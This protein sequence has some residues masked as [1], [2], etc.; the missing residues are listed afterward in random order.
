M[1]FIDWL[2]HAIPLFADANILLLTFLHYEHLSNLM[3]YVKNPNAP[4]NILNL[5]DLFDL[6]AFIY[7][8]H[9]H[10]PPKLLC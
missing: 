2:N 4:L 3:Y 9:G 10:P 5:F 6:Y 7:T 1:S 8:T